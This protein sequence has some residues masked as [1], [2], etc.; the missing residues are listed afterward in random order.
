[1]SIGEVKMATQEA[2][3]ERNSCKKN[4]MDQLQQGLLDD[5]D[6]VWRM[7]HGM[8]IEIDTLH[9][10]QRELKERVRRLEECV[11]KQSARY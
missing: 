2:P 9:D 6:A 4:L 3:E 8:A 1:M 10:Q 7:F 11:R 5:P